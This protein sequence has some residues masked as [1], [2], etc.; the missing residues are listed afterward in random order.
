MPFAMKRRTHMF[1]NTV[2][3]IK[4]SL[5]STFVHC[6]VV[7]FFQLVFFPHCSGGRLLDLALG[8]GP[9]KG[10]AILT[11]CAR[12]QVSF[13]ARWIR[14]EGASCPPRC[15]SV[16]SIAA[17]ATTQRSLVIGDASIHN[18]KKS[19]TKRSGK[20]KNMYISSVPGRSFGAEPC[21]L[22]KPYKFPTLA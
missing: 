17:S 22:R 15:P 20:S 19:K 14:G 16:L 3:L 2:S 4:F 21:W 8:A 7:S 13:N 5:Y 9:P 6:G 11:R 12:D 10:S 1:L 18:A